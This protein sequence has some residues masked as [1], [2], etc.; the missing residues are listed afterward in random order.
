MSSPVVK[1]SIRTL[2]PRTQIERIIGNN[3]T[4]YN[5]L[6][7]NEY[8]RELKHYLKLDRNKHRFLKVEGR[9]INLT[10]TAHTVIR[11]EFKCNACG[12]EAEFFA[13]YRTDDHH[14][15]TCGI[16]FFH[17]EN[18]RVVFHTKDHIIPKSLGGPN[19]IDN[20]Q[21]LCSLCNH[22]KGNDRRD[23]RMCKIFEVKKGYGRDS[24]EIEE[25]DSMASFEIMRR[26]DERS[27]YIDDRTA[28]DLYRGE[29]LE[30]NNMVVM[31]KT[32]FDM[33]CH[34][35][36][37]ATHVVRDLHT[38]NV[39]P[40]PWYIRLFRFDRVIKEYLERY[41]NHVLA[42]C[43]EDYDE[44]AKCNTEISER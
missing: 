15:G 20:Y 34:A 11:D 38:F 16:I 14:N 2:S 21:N 5:I 27:F 19:H 26:Y 28:I 12:R 7:L 36:R 3:A 32:T 22:E 13:I 43:R 25:D 4:A 29:C 44:F 9:L 40:M 23:M 10:D 31:D 1:T 17:I 35:H 41:R 33:Y 8:E 6:P 37:T 18:N 30:G 24:V 42:S 39:G